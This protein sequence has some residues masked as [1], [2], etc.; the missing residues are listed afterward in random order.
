MA[1]PSRVILFGSWARGKAHAKSD[2][3]LLVVVKNVESRRAL[4]AKI[5]EALADIH[6]PA[7]VVVATEIDLR[8]NRGVRGALVN[9]ALEEGVTLYAA[10]RP[11]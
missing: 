3:D 5:Y 4:A 1:G 8:N 10:P 2:V 7:D 11:T 6:I 9:R